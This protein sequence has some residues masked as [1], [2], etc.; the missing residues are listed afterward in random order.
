MTEFPDKIYSFIYI[1]DLLAIPVPLIL[2]DSSISLLINLLY[3]ICSALASFIINFL[4]LIGLSK[5]TSY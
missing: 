1:G 2:A 3:S 5:I 4:Y